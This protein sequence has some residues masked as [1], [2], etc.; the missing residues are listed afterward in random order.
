MALDIL[1]LKACAINQHV[2]LNL[3][4]LVR[5]HTFLVEWLPNQMCPIEWEFM[6]L[7]DCV[8]V[9]QESKD[10]LFLSI[11]LHLF[12]IFHVNNLNFFF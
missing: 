6:I 11:V 12:K 5:I 3:N 1:N 4:Y 2:V 9:E 8:R 10:N 7:F